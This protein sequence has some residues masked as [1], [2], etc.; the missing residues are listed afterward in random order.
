M[1]R[2]DPN[3]C[4]IFTYCPMALVMARAAMTALLCPSLYMSV[5]FRTMTPMSSM[6]PLSTLHAL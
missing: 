1:E 6:I 4:T 2:L 3:W 5:L